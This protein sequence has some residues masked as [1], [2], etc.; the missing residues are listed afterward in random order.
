MWRHACELSWNTGS[1]PHTPAPYYSMPQ[2]I[3]NLESSLVLD[4]M[5]NIKHFTQPDSL[6]RSMKAQPTGLECPGTLRGG[7]GP[8]SDFDSC[9][10]LEQHA[11]SLPESSSQ[12]PHTPQQFRL[13]V[14]ISIQK[15]YNSAFSHCTRPACDHASKYEGWPRLS[16]VYER[17]DR[18][19]RSAI[20]FDHMNRDNYLQ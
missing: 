12:Q 14:P 4:D 13:F 8:T 20:A 1:W 5:N 10:S 2:C 19:M 16:Q 15:D 3:A 18:H 9:G 11:N 6:V 17:G 7:L